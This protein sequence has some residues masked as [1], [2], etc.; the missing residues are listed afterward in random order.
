MDGTSGDGELPIASLRFVDGAYLKV[1]G[2]PVRRGRTLTDLE[3]RDTQ[4]TA[5][6]VNETLARRHWPSADA[7]GRRIRLRGAASP[8]TWFTVVGVVGDV[9]QRQ[10]PGQAENQ[11]YFPL[12]YATEVT[13][14]IRARRDVSGVAGSA[15]DAVRLI[16]DTLA[17]TAG[18]MASTYRAYAADR[19]A[20]RLTL[21]VHRVL[22]AKRREHPTLQFR[23]EGVARQ[24]LDDHAEHD[25]IR[26]RILP[27]LTRGERRLGVEEV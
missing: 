27:A 21:A 23:V 19:Q 7:L 16:D 24:S 11:I 6:L 22:Q 10:L 8:N 20:Q 2:I 5:I 3:A 12:V 13:L 18:T 17:I 1:M 4:G 9:M 15:R 25:V 26:I 14:V